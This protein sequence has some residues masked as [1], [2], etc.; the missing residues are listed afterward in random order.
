MYITSAAQAIAHHPQRYPASPKNN[1]RDE[2]L[3]LPSKLLPFDVI[4]YGNPF[5]Q[6]KSDV[7]ILFPSSN[8]G[9]LLRINMAW[10]NTA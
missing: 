1:R 9:P 4:C 3:P 6:F 10:H 7:H 2:E 8:L 5:S